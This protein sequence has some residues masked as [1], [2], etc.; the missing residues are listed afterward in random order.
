MMMAGVY[1]HRDVSGTL[2]AE[3]FYELPSAKVSVASIQW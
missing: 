2:V 3:V 1:D